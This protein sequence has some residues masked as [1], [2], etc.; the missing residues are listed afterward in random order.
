[1]Y[2]KN[3]SSYSGLLLRLCS[4]GLGS[5][6]FLSIFLARSRTRRVKGRRRRINYDAVPRPGGIVVKQT[7]AADVVGSACQDLREISMVTENNG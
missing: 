6:L 4:G 5:L 1:M 7:V 3:A 2:N